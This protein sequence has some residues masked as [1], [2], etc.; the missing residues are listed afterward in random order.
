MLVILKT[1]SFLLKD[2]HPNAMQYNAHSGTKSYKSLLKQ[3]FSLSFNGLDKTEITNY[4]ETTSDGGW[5][6]QGDM[7][8]L[9]MFEIFNC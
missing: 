5:L 1:T 3:L 6:V 7:V 2:L 9:A 8:I 4:E